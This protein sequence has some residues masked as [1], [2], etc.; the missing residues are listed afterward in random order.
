MRS[1]SD[2]ATRR[3]RLTYGPELK[4]RWVLSERPLA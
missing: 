1:I 2:I 3:F 4:K